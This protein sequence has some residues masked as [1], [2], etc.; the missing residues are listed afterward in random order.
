M[1]KFGYLTQEAL[2]GF[3]A[4]KAGGTCP[5]L[6][7]S[8]CWLVWQAGFEMARYNFAPPAM[9]KKSTGYSVKTR[10]LQGII[11]IKFTGD[12]LDQTDIKINSK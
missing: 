7:S 1:S 10:T 3:N 2:E 4:Y 11:T 5:Y 6:F 12:A 9:A 8:D